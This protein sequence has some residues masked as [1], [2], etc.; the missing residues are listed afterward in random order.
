MGE[1]GVSNMLEGSFMKHSYLMQCVAGESLVYSA[2]I[3]LGV[4]EEM[5]KFIW[6]LK[7]VHVGRKRLTPQA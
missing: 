7:V 5:G 1:K 4:I 2:R 6:K 3:L